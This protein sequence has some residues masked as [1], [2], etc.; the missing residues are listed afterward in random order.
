MKLA[1]L[2]SKSVE[3]YVHSVARWIS[4]NLGIEIDILSLDVPTIHFVTFETLR[5]VLSDLSK[6][7]VV[8]VPGD[9]RM[10]LET[11]SKELGVKIVRGPKNVG[12]LPTVLM[13]L[14][15]EALET[16]VPPEEKLFRDDSLRNA[17]IV[18][19]VA[20]L[21]EIYANGTYLS[22]DDVRIPLRPPPFAVLHE[23]TEIDKRSIDEVVEVSRRVCEL[24]I[25][26]LVLGTSF[27][28]DPTKFDVSSYVRK[29]IDVCGARIGIDTHS[30]SIARRAL[31]EGASGF[32]S[33]RPGFEESLR[34][35]ARSKLF[36][37]IPPMF[38]DVESLLSYVE[39]L[40]SMGFQNLVLDPLLAPPLYGLGRSIVNYVE[41]MKRNPRFPVMAGLGNV[42]ELMDVDSHG[43]IA[44]LVAI[45]GEIGVS[46]YLVSEHSCKAFNAT[47]E[48]IVACAMVSIAMYEGRYPKDMPFSLLLAK[49]KRI[50]EGSTRSTG[51]EL[52]VENACGDASYLPTECPRVCVEL[53][54]AL[55]SL[56]MGSRY[57]G[58]Y[59]MNPR[60]LAK[61]VAE[62][63][64]IASNT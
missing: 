24:G 45:L 14:G 62:A 7:T 3:P 25:E 63:R 19:Y 31:E 46:T 64:R 40:E 35:F 48:T 42:Y 36:V 41:L 53:G 27:E 8:V 28:V 47:S 9:L 43:I 58:I 1:I 13:L 49:P 33:L 22:V 57:P 30:V 52:C 59:S 44:T 56:E 23:V 29:V 6:D 11:L 50:V 32:L 21:T 5:R 51:F 4:T 12:D 26:M 18:D 20:R 10:D 55:R 34:S 61:F 39:K 15:I 38:G 2:C 60:T 54:K 16:E 17:W 37:V